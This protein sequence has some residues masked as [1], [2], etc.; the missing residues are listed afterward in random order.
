MCITIIRKRVAKK[1]TIGKTTFFLG[2]QKLAPIIIFPISISYT[3][4]FNVLWR[5]NWTMAA[6]QVLDR[7]EKLVIKKTKSEG[8]NGGE[9]KDNIQWTFSGALLYSLTVITTI[10]TYIQGG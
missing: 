2:H 8:Y 3:E 4:Q 5:Q 1:R 7:F 9:D 10:G 6:G